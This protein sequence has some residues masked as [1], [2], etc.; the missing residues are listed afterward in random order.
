MSA[1][2]K[3]AANFHEGENCDTEEDLGESEC[4]DAGIEDDEGSDEEESSFRDPPAG[5]VR[6]RPSQFLNIPST[7]FIEYPPE[8]GIKRNDCSKLEELR[9]RRLSFKSHW[10]RICV[11]NAFRRA[12]FVQSDRMWTAMWSK[13]QSAEQMGELNCLQK[14][15]HFP[16]SWYICLII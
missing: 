14:V 3:Q 1:D 13:H 11:N 12:G 15:N 9:H 2:E 8:L 16:S 4:I 5:F 7:V 10:E 6:L